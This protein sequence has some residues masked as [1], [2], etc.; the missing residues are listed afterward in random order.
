MYAVSSTIIT[1]AVLSFTK[2]LLPLRNVIT[3]SVDVISGF[4]NHRCR[5]RTWNVSSSPAAET[6]VR[7]A[8]RLLHSGRDLG[9]GHSE[10]PRKSSGDLYFTFV[11]RRPCRK[12]RPSRCQWWGLRSQW[13]RSG[14]KNSRSGNSDCTDPLFRVIRKQNIW[15]GNVLLVVSPTS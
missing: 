13:H 1:L 6:R 15:M 4:R 5:R 11:G 8:A 3:D 12:Y 10:R 9:Q 14:W 2:A 7:Q